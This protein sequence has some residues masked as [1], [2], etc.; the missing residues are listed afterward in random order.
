MTR[1]AER[2]AVALPDPLP[3]DD[4]SFDHLEGER[5]DIATSQA[6]N[7]AHRAAEKFPE[8]AERYRNFAGPAAVASGVLV[9]LAGVALAR[10]VKRGQHPEQALAELT[11]DEIE[12]AATVTHRKNVVWN[13]IRR[14]AKRRRQAQA[15]QS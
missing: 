10:R 13:M 15:E 6:L 14:I 5:P 7:L 11:S 8:L 3:D 1:A 2:P 4:F 9:V 12:Q